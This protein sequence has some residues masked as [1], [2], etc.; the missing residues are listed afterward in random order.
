MAPHSSTLAWKIQWME[1]PGRRQSMGSHRVGHDWAT[2]LP[3]PFTVSGSVNWC[4]TFGGQ[5]GTTFRSLK[6][7]CPLICHF[8]FQKF[9]L[10]VCLYFKGL[11]R[12]PSGKESTCQCRRHK[13]LRFDSWVRKIPWRRKMTTHYGIFTWKIPWTEEPGGLQSM[14]SSNWAHT[15]SPMKWLTS[16]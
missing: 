7:V 9:I 1:E 10:D 4:N 11:P 12:W 3:F 2:S 16:W 6:C 8:Y 5:F 15:K 13:W 14:G